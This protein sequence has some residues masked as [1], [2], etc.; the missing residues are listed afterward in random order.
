MQQRS[1]PGDGFPEQEHQQHQGRATAQKDPSDLTP[2]ERVRSIANAL[3]GVLLVTAAAGKWRVE[4]V[5]DTISMP[6]FGDGSGARKRRL[7][8]DLEEDI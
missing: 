8:I 4:Q 3:G 1:N 5:E 6:E 2:E 7:V